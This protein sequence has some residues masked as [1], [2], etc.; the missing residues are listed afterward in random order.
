MSK[1]QTKIA[2]E[3]LLKEVTAKTSLTPTNL[4]SLTILSKQEEEA[5]KTVI[6]GTNGP[7]EDAH[8]PQLKSYED[9]AQ[10]TT[11]VKQSSCCQIFSINNIRY[12]NELLNHPGLIK[13]LSADYSFSDILDLSVGLDQSLVSQAIENNDHELLLAGLLS[14]HES[15]TD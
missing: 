4:I 5:D 12:D 6:K 8:Q 3:L 9:H 10:P 2:E 13:E 1:Y 15:V 7:V 14:L 11:V